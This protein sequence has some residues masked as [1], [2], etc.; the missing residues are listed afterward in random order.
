MLS[1]MARSVRLLS[2][3][4][5]RNGSNNGL[6]PLARVGRLHGNCLDHYCYGRST[7]L[8]NW[9]AA[10]GSLPSR[11]TGVCL[12]HKFRAVVPQRPLLGWW[13]ATAAVPER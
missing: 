8:R 7:H 1:V 12:Q 5:G 13:L 9:S 4:S 6:L 3:T 10:Q 11:S 2:V